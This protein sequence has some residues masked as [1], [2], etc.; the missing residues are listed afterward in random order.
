MIYLTLLSIISLILAP[1]TLGKNIYQ[2]GVYK[3]DFALQSNIDD[4]V[5]DFGLLKRDD[6]DDDDEPSPI[7][8]SK[9]SYYFLVNATLG[10]PLDREYTL[11]FQLEHLILIFLLLWAAEMLRRIHMITVMIL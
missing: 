5:Q 8:L 1:S 3:L 6:D 4:P 11:L 9:D 2:N 10:T 7:R